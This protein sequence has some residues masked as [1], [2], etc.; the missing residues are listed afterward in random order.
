MLLIPGVSSNSVK[1]NTKTCHGLSLTKILEQM[2]ETGKGAQHKDQH[3]I[4]RHQ[5]ST[6]VGSF[7][8]TFMVCF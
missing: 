1:L 3:N 6:D 2:E 7:S 8:W 4:Y 5:T